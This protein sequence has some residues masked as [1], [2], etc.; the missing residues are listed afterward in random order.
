M[1]GGPRLR[2]AAV[3]CIAAV[4]LA[5]CGSSESAPPG[6]SEADRYPSKLTFTQVTAGGVTQAVAC[7]GVGGP[8]IVYVNGLIV[9][10]NSTWQIEAISQAPNNRVCVVDRA[11]TGDSPPRPASATPNGPV[12]NA[13]ELLA[14]LQAVGEKGPYVYVAWSYGGIVARSAIALSPDTAAGLVLV[15]GSIPSGYKSFDKRGWEEAGQKLD[16]AAGYA[17]IGSDSGPSLGNKP[18]VVL[19]AGIDQGRTSEKAGW[20]SGQLAAAKMS[21]NSVFGVVTGAIHTIPQMQSG[22]VVAATNAVI[23]SSRNSNA[24]LGTCPATFPSAGI[25]CMPH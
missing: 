13:K 19:E 17:L 5:A 23:D 12:P 20:T 7:A 3:A 1:T 22:A 9:G 11:G 2:L 16:M 15:E 8:T 4:L 25:Q 10:G 18:L 14:A 21:T 24:P 6:P